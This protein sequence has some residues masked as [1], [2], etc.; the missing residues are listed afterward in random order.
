[1]KLCEWLP[2]Q[3]GLKNIYDEK[4]K[5]GT[6]SP[7]QKL[8]SLCTKLRLDKIV[9]GVLGGSVGGYWNAAKN[10]QKVRIKKQREEQKEEVR[11]E[12]EDVKSQKGKK[13]TNCCCFQNWQKLKIQNIGIEKVPKFR[14]IVK[15][16]KIL[17]SRFVRRNKGRVKVEN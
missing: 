8:F 4:C 3:E 6:K 13:K 5:N 10:H 14:L 2:P 12:E 16:K 11:R 9:R 1:L 15:D 17:L 7:K